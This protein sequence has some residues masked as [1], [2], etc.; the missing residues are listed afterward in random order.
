VNALH[1]TT[2]TGTAGTLSREA[3]QYQFV[4]AAQADARSA[5]SLT[6]CPIGGDRL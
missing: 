6:V 1:V 2:P 3:G 4:Y 5:V